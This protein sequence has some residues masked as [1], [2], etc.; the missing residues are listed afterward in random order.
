MIESTLL[1]IVED[2]QARGAEIPSPLPRQRRIP[3][4]VFEFIGE[5]R[6]RVVNHGDYIVEI[7][8]LVAPVS[9]EEGF[10]GSWDAVAEGV[11]KSRPG[12]GA[13]R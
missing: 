9:E 2:L 8:E 1:F 6:F 13:R 12:A 3:G 11:R 7:G 10:C 5:L 4:F